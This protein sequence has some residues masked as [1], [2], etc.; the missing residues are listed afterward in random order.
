MIKPDFM[1]ENKIIEFY[2][3]YIHANPRLFQKTDVINFLGGSRL[4][5]DIWTK[6]AARLEV[7]RNRGYE[8]MVVW[9]MDSRQRHTLEQ[10]LSFLS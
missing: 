9:E 4:V 1:Y 6:D 3:D 10:C 7:L 8:I 5:G 2:G